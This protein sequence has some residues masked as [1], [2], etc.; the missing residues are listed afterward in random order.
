M[1]GDLEEGLTGMKRKENT[2]V[3]KDQV[4][5]DDVADD[6]VDGEEGGNADQTDD[7]TGGDDQT[8]D[9]DDTGDGDDERKAEFDKAA[10][11]ASSE[12]FFGKFVVSATTVNNSVA[13]KALGPTVEFEVTRMRKGSYVASLN[14][15]PGKEGR[16][17]NTAITKA[18]E[19]SGFRKNEFV[20]ADPDEAEEQ[21]APL[22]VGAGDNAPKVYFWNDP[23]SEAGGRLL[24]VADKMKAGSSKMTTGDLAK[25][26]GELEV[27]RAVIEA[28]AIFKEVGFVTE[29]GEGE[30]AKRGNAAWGAFLRELFQGDENIKAYVEAKNRIGQLIQFASAPDSVLELVSA[31]TCTTFERKVNEAVATF[32]GAVAEIYFKRVGRGMD[33]TFPTETQLSRCI[34]KHAANVEG[35]DREFKEWSEKAAKL[36]AKDKPIPKF[37]AGRANSEN[38]IIGWLLGDAPTPETWHGSKLAKALAKEWSEQINAPTDHEKVETEAKKATAA[39]VKKFPEYS[40]EAAV[41]HLKAQ[42]VSHPAPEEVL[43]GLAESFKDWLVAKAAKMEADKAEAEKAA[44]EA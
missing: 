4:D 9:Q 27:G 18:I 1:L 6:Q 7:Q 15:K 25:K 22:P 19:A 17:P 26:E 13:L 38:A 14:G 36:A 11:A 30:D 31:N 39:I 10:E 35:Y 24:K 2:E 28:K 32:V 5:G 43:E 37:E 20:V 8:D 21:Q 44:A 42:L 29:G 41:E 23:S 33:T 40:I 3:T 16:Q 34:E 12:P